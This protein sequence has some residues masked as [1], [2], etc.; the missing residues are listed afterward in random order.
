MPHPVPRQR[1]IPIRGILSPPLPPP[2]Q[3]RLHLHPP[4]PQQR[5][6]NP[7]SSYTLYLRRDPSQPLRPSPAHHLHHHRLRL[8]VERMRSSHDI[9]HSTRHQPTQRLIPQLPRSLL[10]SLTLRRPPSRRIHPKHLQRD[11]HP[12]TQLPYERLIPIRLRA[13]QPMMH[14]RRTQH[15]TQRLTVAAFRST[16]PHPIRIRLNQPQ[17]QRHRIRP[18]THRHAHPLARPQQSSVHRQ[19]RLRRHPSILSRPAFLY[20]LTSIL[21]TLY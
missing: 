6:H 13:P 2:P 21:Y 15:H 8:V 4:N 18:T 14:M 12:L 17:Q 5:P 3:K 11:P 20:P 9:H 1:H 16:A 19:H 10:Q 7:P